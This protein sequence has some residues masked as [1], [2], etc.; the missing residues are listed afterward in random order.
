MGLGKHTNDHMVSFY[1]RSPSG[2]D[3]EFGYDGLLV[4]EATWTVTQITEAQLLG[5]PPAGGIAPASDSADRRPSGQ[6]RRVWVPHASRKSFTTWQFETLSQ[7]FWLRRSRNGM[8]NKTPSVN[9]I[10]RPATNPATSQGPAA[11]RSA[12]RRGHPDI[13]A[14]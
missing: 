9:V 7:M 12:L 2:F 3:V 1:S 11:P 6:C 13:E 8:N 14:L 4:D 10:A 5:S